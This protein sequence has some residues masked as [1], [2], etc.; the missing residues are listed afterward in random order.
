MTG[1]RVIV[2]GASGLIGR[3]LV[4][5]LA[6]RGYQVVG[7]SRSGRAVPGAAGNI[8]CDLLDAAQMDAAIAAAKASHLVHLAWAD[9]KDRW[10]TPDND[11]W[12]D[13][14]AALITSFARSGGKRAVCAGSCAE[15]DWTG[16]VL[17]ES[18]PL[19]PATR[20]GQAKV[21]AFHDT[22]RVA[23]E[24]GISLAWAR[25]FFVYGPGEPEGR[26]IGD[27]VRGL[28]A[29]REVPCTDGL[30]RRD[31]LS[32]EDLAR[33]LAMLLDSALT[34][35]VN[36]ASG[37]AI[38]VRDLIA[39]VASQ[40]GRPDLVRMGARQRPADD[41]AELCAD[42]ALARRALGFRPAMTLA[43][44]VRALLLAERVAA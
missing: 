1:P 28:R 24:N 2:T 25:P 31:Y 14:T 13:A 39:E 6:V 35:P 4:A 23:A 34:G 18:T 15:Y 16:S 19:R 17:S 22:A 10:S 12:A 33:G 26:L 30:Q 21:R 32:V 9:G 29:G 43:E 40:I 3:P 44:G 42:V 37:E 8:A 27:L 20:Y 36:I 5:A 38:A 41:P 11:R 7:I